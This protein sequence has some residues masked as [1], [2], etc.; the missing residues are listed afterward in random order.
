MARRPDMKSPVDRKSLGAFRLTPALQAAALAAAADGILITDREGSILWVNPAFL[1]QSGYAEGEVIG[2]TPRLLR[3][4]RH[5]PAFYRAFWKTILGGETWRGEMINRR[6]DGTLYQ[7]WL[8]VTPV[9]SAAG[10]ITH[11]IA[12]MLDITE[13]KR[14]EE[15]VRQFNT[16]LED[17]VRQRTE[18]LEAANKELEAFSYS[19][20]HDLRAPLRHIDGYVEL[21]R[22]EPGA[23]LPGKS[24]HYLDQIADS[25]RRMGRL[26]ADLL[27]FSKTARSELRRERVELGKLVEEAIRQLEPEAGG[28]TLVWKQDR[29]PDVE[30]DRSLLR[31]ALANLLANAVKFTRPRPA[32]EISIGCASQTRAEAVVFIRDNGVGFD[33]KYAGNLFGAFQRLHSAAEFEGTGIGL[34]NVRRIIARH[35]GRTWAESKPGGGATFY[36]S[37]PKPDNDSR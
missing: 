20:S 11:F 13:R 5:E 37:L 2:N 36:F 6:R 32:A 29:L 1:K 34:A 14:V 10:E 25:A 8:T 22:H 3:S 4:G 31:L 33:M 18:E 24:R 28:R 35:G 19:V 7:E 23:R 12:I 9:R 26:I 16:T 27:T 15:Q 21:L 30:G 17:R